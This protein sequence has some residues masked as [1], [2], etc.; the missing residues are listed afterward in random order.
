MLKVRAWHARHAPRDAE[1]LVRLLS[2]VTDVEAVRGELKPGE[3]QG[4]AQVAP[5][6]DAANRAWRTVL[7]RDDAQAA[8]A[9]L[10]D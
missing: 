5:L 3:R 7:N 4:L 1:D 10:A 9:R 2:L 6:T 8:F